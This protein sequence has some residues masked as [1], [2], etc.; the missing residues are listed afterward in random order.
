LPAERLLPVP[1][2]ARYLGIS[3]RSLWRLVDDDRLRPV[4][5]P[6]LRRVAFDVR[7]LDAL[8]EASRD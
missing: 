7:D 3:V 2:A 6:G 5:L 1:R 4:R 8:I